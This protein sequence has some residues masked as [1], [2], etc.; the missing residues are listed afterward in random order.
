M[1]GPSR[2]GIRH[3]QA[4]PEHYH[5][6]LATVAVILQ[7]QPR[8]STLRSVP[9]IVARSS[10]LGLSLVMDLWWF[11]PRRAV[12]EA[13][14]ASFVLVSRKKKIYVMHGSIKDYGLILSIGI[15]SL[16][17]TRYIVRFIRIIRIMHIIHI[18]ALA[19]YTSNTSYTSYA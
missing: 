14:F 6:E 1:A 18:N 2:V 8:A 5:L 7:Q 11:V 19:S 16:Y 4:P 9:T 10:G 12:S 15:P 3:R 17:H 13:W